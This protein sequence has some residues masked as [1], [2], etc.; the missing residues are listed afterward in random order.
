MF[1]AI[2]NDDLEKD[3]VLGSFTTDENALS[4]TL[5]RSTKVFY[6]RFLTAIYAVFAQL[7]SLIKKE[8]GVKK[9][10]KA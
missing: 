4:R 1:Q 7:R 10:V 6:N 8:C 9:G 2:T 3:V 5:E